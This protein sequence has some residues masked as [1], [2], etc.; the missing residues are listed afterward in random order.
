MSV[1][2][3]NPCVTQSFSVEAVQTIVLQ[4]ANQI[5]MEMVRAL[6]SGL[7]EKLNFKGL[8]EKHTVVTLEQDLAA[9]DAKTQMVYQKLF[10]VTNEHIRQHSQPLVT[11]FAMMN[12]QTNNDQSAGMFLGSFVLPATKAMIEKLQS[13]QPESLECSEIWG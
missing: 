10:T 12:Q 8:A 5:A 13:E 4:T 11:T 6:M 2:L 3:Q 1:N 9:T 7:Q